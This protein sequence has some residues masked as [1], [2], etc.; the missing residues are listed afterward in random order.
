MKLKYLFITLLLLS[1]IGCNDSFLDR[2]PKDQL[3]DES[4]WSV[5]EDAVKYTTSIYR[6]LVSPSDHMIMLD[7]YTDNAVPVHIFAEQG[8]ISSGVATASNPHFKQ[9]WQNAYRGIRR[10]NVFLNNIS[11]VDMK[12]DEKTILI[13]EVEFLRA[14]FHATLLKFYGGIPI[15]TKTLEL[16]EV[17]PARNTA[18]EVYDFI[19][20]ECDK[21][22]E[23][24]P[25]TRTNNAELG[26]ANRG[27][28]IALKAH[29]SYLMKKY[30]VAASAAKAVMDLNI[31]KLY[32]N[33]GDLF[34]PDYENNSEVIFDRQAMENAFD[35]N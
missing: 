7:C 32:D 22:V 8:D 9:V 4:F 12:E 10:C 20:K 33:Y 24:L 29:I 3:S 19:L 14:Y 31:Y 26:H 18:E 30:D 25:L 27:A 2:M 35:S 21:A 16:N 6:Y 13:G 1:G 17:I 5:K 34:L 28:A 15:L 23:K 11:K